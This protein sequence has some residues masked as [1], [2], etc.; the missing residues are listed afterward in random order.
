V[1]QK[2]RA[3]LT[4]TAAIVL[5][6]GTWL[7]HAVLS[8]LPHIADIHLQGAR[9]STIIL[10]REGRI[11]ATLSDPETGESYPL[12]P[13]RI[14][15]MVKQAAVATEDKTFYR[16]PGFDALAILRAAWRNARQ[17]KIVS[18]ASTIT[19]QVAR[20]L[21]LPDQERY[22]PTLL[23][24]LRELV[25]AYQLTH[26]FSKDE[27]LSLYLNQAYFGNL[28]YGIE[29]AAQ[30]YFDKPA[31]H[32]NLAESAL[33]VGLIQAPIAYDP[34]SHPEAALS[35][36]ATVLEL[37][38]EQGYI[39]VDEATLT[40]QEPLTLSSSDASHRAPHFVVM[41]R[42][43]IGK[44]LPAAIQH[45]GG[46]RIYTTLDLSLQR[47][48]EERVRYHLA[49]LNAE[50]SALPSHEVH[51]AA[52]VVLDPHTGAIRALVGSPDYDKEEI[53]GAFNGALALRQPGS[54]LKPF[55][56][57]AAFEQGL[58]P[59][60]VIADVPTSFPTRTG[61]SYVPINYDYRYHGL[62]TLREALACSYNVVAVKLLDRIGVVRLPEMAG[63]L[64]I[65]TLEDIGDHGLALTL[66]S[67]EVSLLELTA[68]YAAFANGGYRVTPWFITRI[69]DEEGRLLYEHPTTPPH[70]V[71]DPRI[72][73]LISQVL[74]DPKARTSA[75]GEGSPLELP[76]QAAVKTGTTTDWRDNW[77]VGYS[78]ETVVGV[79]VGN[80]DNRPMRGVSGI[81]GAAPIWN[82]VMRDAHSRIPEPFAR[83]PGIVE[84]EVCSLSGKLPNPDCPYREKELF[85]AEYQPHETCSLHHKVIVDVRTGELAT[86]DCPN[87]YR[88]GKVITL[89]PSEVLDWAAENG[90]L[91]P[92]AE[93]LRQEQIP[94]N[95]H[96]AW[97][98]EKAS[99]LKIVEPVSGST[100]RLSPELASAAQ[101]I[102]IRLAAHAP[103]VFAQIELWVD[104]QRQAS[105]PTPPYRT[106]WPLEP[107]THR[108]EARG[109][110][111][112]GQFISSPAVEIFV[113][114][115][116]ERTRP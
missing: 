38:A 8:G 53:A 35:R 91:D 65:T 110:L 112:D 20:N 63:R 69:Q 92:L 4:A 78:T 72:A 101:Q 89:W 99:W 85:L 34:F 66:G 105:W 107:G 84:I 88:Q 46:L 49:Q 57:A 87:L 106:F 52:V 41:V 58:S 81:S 114:P 74:S 44:L 45:A 80:A 47:A 25:L 29:A 48:A 9:P 98:S 115:A 70:Q 116:S 102:E 17:G 55:T 103:T 13:E 14:P 68:A 104:E 12:P 39:S 79:W 76:F 93:R 26:R 111:I 6:L 94:T 37:M 40:A 100:F 56:Y 83:P 2:L 28:A 71:L 61:S 97:A 60:T 16:N 5:I 21:L 75:F 73:Y 27:I 62:V 22:Q 90:L 15:E 11:I 33:L 31:E 77:T 113:Y 1:R 67:C 19:Q 51:N 18:G 50:T 43:Q 24:K 3:T 10:D 108:L 59:A 82:A 54:A 96:L 109:R 86:P 32:L 95:Q 64:G 23:R 42:Q 30:T 7:A 36:R